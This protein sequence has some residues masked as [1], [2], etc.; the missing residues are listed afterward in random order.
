MKKSTKRSIFGGIVGTI[1]VTA[2]VGTSLLSTPS[3]N[4]DYDINNVNEYVTQLS[5]EEPKNEDIDLIELYCNDKLVDKS[6]F[7]DGSFQSVPLIFTNLNNLEIKMYKQ[8]QYVGSAKF[9]D[10]REL[11]YE[12]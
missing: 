5:I 12:N 1:V 4:I 6:I 11:I 2:A 8:G 10:K 3:I 9:N 7:P